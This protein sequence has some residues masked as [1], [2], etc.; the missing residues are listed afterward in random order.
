MIQLP[1]AVPL[2]L[3]TGV[4]AAWS[5]VKYRRL[6][7][8]LALLVAGT[9]LSYAA[10]YAGLSAAGSGLLHGLAALLVGLAL[11][12]RGVVG[13]G[14]IKYYAAVATWFPLGQGFRLLGLVSLAGLALVLG[15]LIWRK[16]TG[17]TVNLRAR[18]DSDKLP[19]GVAIASGAVLA[20][21]GNLP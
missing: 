16:L 9:G 14:D 18:E 12:S 5:D 8:V 10:I 7:N 11:Y 2:L 17:R 4:Y 15:W 19:F 1:L 21:I 20:A 3:G 6:P 13:G